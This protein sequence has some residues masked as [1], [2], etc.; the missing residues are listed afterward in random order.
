MNNSIT[1]LWSQR[2]AQSSDSPQLEV[3][4]I[5]KDADTSE[6][7]SDSPAN[8]YA[9]RTPS[10]TA[11]V[12]KDDVMPEKRLP[13][14]KRKIT[15]ESESFIDAK[16]LKARSSSVPRARLSDLGGVDACIEEVLELI[17]M[18]LAHPE[19]YLHTGVQPP[20]Y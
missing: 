18:P 19:I 9:L 1:R 4:S 6:I 3:D 10:K 2:L 12:T 7:I 14:N 16:K 11:I 5:P 17:V 20:R 8:P 15:Q 13:K